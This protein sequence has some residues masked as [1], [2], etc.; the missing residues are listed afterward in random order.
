MNIPAALLLAVLTM[1]ASAAAPAPKF[2]CSAPKGWSAVAE[3]DGVT[4]LG[5][6]DDHHVAA[7]VNVRYVAPGNVSYAD[8]DAY[9]ARLTKKPTAEVPGWKT[10]PVENTSVAGRPSRRVRL[11]TSEFV[12]PHSRN[13]KEVPM[14][15]EHVVIPAAKGFYVVFFYAPKSIAKKNRA[16]LRAVLKSFKPRL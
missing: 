3:E 1:P 10:Y 12:P 4:Y 13:T 11:D 6:L 16:A 8:P 15:E 7:Q 14:S 2:D 5:P 9:V